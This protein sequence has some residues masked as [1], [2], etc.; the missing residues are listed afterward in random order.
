MSAVHYLKMSARASLRVVTNM[1]FL[2]LKNDESFTVVRLF[3]KAKGSSVTKKFKF[4]WKVLNAAV[5]LE[6]IFFWK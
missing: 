5:W 6:A 3:S 4:L 2:D 1:V